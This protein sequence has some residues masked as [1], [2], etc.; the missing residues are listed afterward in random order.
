MNE[1]R[2]KRSER[3]PLF[4]LV[5][6][7]VQNIKYTFDVSKKRIFVPCTALQE[8]SRERTGILK[9]YSDNPCY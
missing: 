1:G 7:L 4:F 6:S 8:Y 3:V 9:F 2:D 5:L